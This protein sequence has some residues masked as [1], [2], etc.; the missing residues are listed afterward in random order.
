MNELNI[1]LKL[2]KKY[3]NIFY[4]IF[5]HSLYIS[6]IIAILGLLIFFIFSMI[7]GFILVL[8]VCIYNY[9]IFELIENYLWEK[10]KETML[11][12]HKLY[13]YN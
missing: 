5:Y 3:K 12:I 9:F 7:I 1:N 11:E 6:L 10:A 13:Y 2:F 8:V 4:Y